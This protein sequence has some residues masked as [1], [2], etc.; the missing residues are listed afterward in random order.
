MIP[1]EYPAGG[2]APVFHEE[3]SERAPEKNADHI[4]EIEADGYEHY[5]SVIDAAGF[6]GDGEG[7]NHGSP[8]YCN[9]ISVYC[10]SLDEGKETFFVYVSGYVRPVDVLERIG[11][12]EECRDL[13]PRKNLH[14]MARI[15]SLSNWHV[16]DAKKFLRAEGP[17]PGGR[18]KLHN[19]IEHPCSPKDV[20]QGYFLEEIHPQHDIKLIRLNKKEQDCTCKNSASGQ[21][22]RHIYSSERFLIDRMRI[23]CHAY[24]RGSVLRPKS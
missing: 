12:A 11:L 4:A 22:T 15:N 2:T 13:F 24:L 5:D 6:E 9:V 17:V 21:E 8:D 1:V 7:C 3:N 16:V 10:T 18:N 14:E 20:K 19:H 23:V